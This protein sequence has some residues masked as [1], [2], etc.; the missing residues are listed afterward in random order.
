MN[1]CNSINID[2]ITFIPRFRDSFK[3]DTDIKLETELLK[4]VDGCIRDFE[5]WA[6]ISKKRE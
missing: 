3:K 4:I 5:S 2:V 1:K 6:R